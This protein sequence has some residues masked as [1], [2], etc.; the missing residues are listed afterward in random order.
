MQE[1]QLKMESRSNICNYIFSPDWPPAYSATN[2][3]KWTT[4]S[5]I[6][7]VIKVYFHS[8][9]CLKVSFIVRAEL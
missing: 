6:Y 3:K 1:T 4:F 8:Q 7:Q 9:T 5:E 2:H